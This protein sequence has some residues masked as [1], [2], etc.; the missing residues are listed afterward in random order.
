M[1]NQKGQVMIIVI[2][3]III[4]GFAGLLFFVTRQV[5]QIWGDPP[6]TPYP[7]PV[8]TSAPVNIATWK[9]YISPGYGFS[10]K[11]PKDWDKLET[12][13]GKYIRFFQGTFKP[14]SP[15]PQ[16]YISIQ[17]NPNNTR[18]QLKDWLVT[19]NVLPAQNNPGIQIQEKAI[20]IGSIS[21]IMVTTPT[22]GSQDTV[23]LPVGSNILQATY[24]YVGED[25]NEYDNLFKT[26]SQVI[27]TLQPLAVDAKKQ[28]Y[29]CPQNGWVN[30]MPILSPEGEKQCSGEAVEWYKANCPN[31]Q[32]VAL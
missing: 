19:Q 3:A 21:G 6:K 25:Q 20:A 23:Y 2:L 14:D 1:T 11:Y 8:M 32:G 5:P 16:T 26:F 10:L 18:Q 27:S 17:V 31:F 29:V 28:S 30:C 22:R 13:K 12:G 4:I 7:A 9:V 24:M 15:L